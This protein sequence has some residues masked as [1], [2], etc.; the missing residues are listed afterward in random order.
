MGAYA[1]ALLGLKA[2][3]PYLINIMLAVIA[4]VVLAALIA[5]PVRRLKSHYFALATLGIAEVVLIGAREWESLT[6]GANGLHGVPAIG[7]LGIAVPRG[8]GEFAFVWGVAGLLAWL[9]WRIHRGLPTRRAAVARADP[10]AAQSAGI[11]TDRLRFD[12]FLLSAGYGAVAGAL[13]VP[14]VRV[15]SPEVVG[16]QVM[17]TCLAIT[18]VGGRLRIAGAFVGALLLYPLPEWFRFLEGQELIAYGAV[19]LV[20]VLLAPEGI[21]GLA[22][23]LA[24]WSAAPT[25]A[26][27]EE[28]SDMPSAPERP[29]SDMALETRRIGKSFGGL[30]ALDNV[31]LCIE[32]GTIVGLIGPNGAGKTTLANVITGQYRAD[33]GGCVSRRQA[34]DP[35]TDLSDCARWCCPH[36]S[37]PC[38]GR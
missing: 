3:T 13:A 28:T 9:A 12:A 30:K 22:D 16:F 21:T 4:T 15:I 24:P 35:A 37:D 26:V 17:V 11:D 20:C 7:M 36:V 29:A 8:W 34:V 5:I 25:L 1:T 6:G 19:M 38:F 10:I 33:T 23:K 14:V 18:V 27:L 2:G 32:P 31:S